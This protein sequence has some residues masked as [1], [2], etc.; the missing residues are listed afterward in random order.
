MN[1]FLDMAALL[2]ALSTYRVIISATALLLGSIIGVIYLCKTIDEH[3]T[4]M[5]IWHAVPFIGR[6]ASLSREKPD[7]TTGWPSVETKLCGKYLT[8]YTDYP[9]TKVG[10]YLKSKDYLAKIG[11]AGRR[12]MPMWVLALSFA[13]LIL[14]A[15]G[16]AFVLGPWINPN[17]SATQMGYLAWSVAFFLALISG[18]FAHFAGHHVHYN[19]IIK[20]AHAWWSHDRKNTNRP[21]SLKQLPAVS[22]DQTYDDNEQP[23]Y[24]QIMTRITADANVAQKRA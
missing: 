14:E 18:F 3:Y 21:S 20:K 22:I 16:F 4:L 6:I 7:S 9:E 13:L 1:E 23:D 19:S 17:V 8:H 24:Q 2:S 15:V 10:L 5:R 11:E 12:P